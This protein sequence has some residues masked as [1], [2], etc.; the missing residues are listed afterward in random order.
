MSIGIGDK[1]RFLNDVGGGTV[2][3]LLPKNMAIVE[4]A[5]EFEYPYPTNELVM[6]EKAIVEEIVPQRNVSKNIVVKAENPKVETELKDD[7]ISEIL[8]EFVRKKQED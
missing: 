1:V 6:V 4:D 3:K 2:V 5:D 8:F 7:D